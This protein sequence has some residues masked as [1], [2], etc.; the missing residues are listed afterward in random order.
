VVVPA[1]IVPAV[2]EECAA[3]GVKGIVLIAAGF[4]EIDDPQGESLHEQLTEIVDRAHIP[5]IGP[6]TFG[7]V[8]LHSMLNASFTPEFS[9]LKKGNIGLVSQS[10][11]I[12]H[13]LSFLAI[14]SGIG[15]S[16][17]VG[18]GNRLNV[19]FAQMVDYLMHDPDTDV[20]MLYMEGV[21]RPNQLINIAGNF[22][23][24]KPIIAYKTGT[25]DLG[26]K[27]SRSHTGSLAGNKEIY[28]GAFSQAGILTV[29]SAE[30]L[31]DTAKALAVSP[32][33]GGPGVAILSSQAGPGIAAA[34][35][36]QM[37]GLTIASFTS[38]TQ[39]RIN[40][41]LP[42]LALRVNPVDMGPAWYNPDAIVGIL[43][44]V[45]EDENVSGILLFMMFA[46]ANI[47]SIKGFSFLIED[48]M[49]KKPLIACLSA[50][51]GIW[52]KHIEHFEEAGILVNFPTPE[53]AAKV[54][55]NLNRYRNLIHA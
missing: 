2:F 43:Q 40:E 7:M 10:G 30:D 3:K 12:S 5:V 22:R 24:K 13:L 19:D 11:G 1:K 15:F 52:D 17:I 39:N 29:N 49:P 34:D 54:M 37:G 42:P 25:G 53:R 8:N 18:I 14:R 50:P 48:K 23:G 27:A 21:E 36:C 9:L 31:L 55:V 32:V 44:A 6:N 28:S 45:I 47:D 46:S 38:N 33:P 20:I 35:I 26:N 41:I 16:K 51:P 4:K